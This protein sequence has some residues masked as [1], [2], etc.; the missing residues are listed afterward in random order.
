MFGEISWVKGH[1]AEEAAAVAA[2]AAVVAATVAAGSEGGMA[3]ADSE[4]TAADSEGTAAFTEGT[5]VSDMDP[6]GATAD[7]ATDRRCGCSFHAAGAASA[8]SS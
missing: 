1:T 8:S 5:A 4:G 6:A 3:A 7:L 2:T